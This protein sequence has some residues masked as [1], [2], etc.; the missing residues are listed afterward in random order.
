MVT[1]QQFLSRARLGFNRMWLVRWCKALVFQIRLNDEKREADY[2]R[3]LTGKKMLVLC[4]AGRPLC[5]SKQ[6]VKQLIKE[7]YYKHGTTPE[8]VEKLALYKTA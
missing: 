7:G 2:R 3:G 1:L 5:V 8:D 6:R 4:V